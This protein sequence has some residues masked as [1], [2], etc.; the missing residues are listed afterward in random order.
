M[1]GDEEV[2][3]GDVGRVWGENVNDGGEGGS[4]VVD[5]VIWTISVSI[6][7]QLRSFSSCHSPSV[8]HP[9]TASFRPPDS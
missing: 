8:I 2:E 4:S 5:D 7:Y 1:D 6:C 9:C 3:V